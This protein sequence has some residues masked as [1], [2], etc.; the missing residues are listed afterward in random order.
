MLT[1]A[2]IGAILTLAASPAV[3]QDSTIWLGTSTGGVLRSTNAGAGFTQHL[4][5]LPSLKVYAIAPSPTLPEDGIVVAATDVGIAYSSDRGATWTAAPGAPGVRTAGI[6]A[7]PRFESDRTF[8]AISDNGVLSRS[9]NSGAN[10]SAVSANPGN[11]LPRDVNFNGLIAVQGR[12]QNIHLFTWI[13]TN[14]WVSDDL[15]RSFRSVLGKDALP[16][17]FRITAVAVHPDWHYESVIW[18]GSR[19]HGVYRSEDAGEKFVNVLHNPRHDSDAALGQIN[20]IALSPNLPRD[21]TIVVG[22]ER[23]SVFLS[24]RSERQGTVKNIGAPSS[25]DNKSAS[26]TVGN[27]RGLGF[28]NGF[29]GDD[30]IYA[31]GGTQ[32]AFTGNAGNDWYTYPHDAGPTS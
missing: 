5:G 17:D 30:T 8:Y 29:S 20:V 6:D 15:G 3:F 25:W 27:V 11:G 31:A 32:F 19:E 2:P 23:G 9:T 26:L 12:G 28:S 14:L 4:G 22:T 16:K 7:S 18:L 24:K 13:S 1:S 21:G 10:W